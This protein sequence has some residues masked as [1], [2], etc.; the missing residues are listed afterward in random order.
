MAMFRVSLGPRNC[1][2]PPG[3]AVDDPLRR[4]YV[5]DAGGKRIAIFDLDSFEFIRYFGDAKSEEQGRHSDQSQ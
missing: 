4:L 5:A 1:S 3:L 2:V